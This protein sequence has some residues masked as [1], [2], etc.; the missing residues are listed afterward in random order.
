MAFSCRR[1]ALPTRFRRAPLAPITIG[2]CPA[3]STQMEASTR[4]CCSL[5]GDFFHL[6]RN[7][8]GHLLIEL[9]GEAFADEFGDAKRQIA[10]GERTRRKHRRCHRQ[11]LR[12]AAAQHI[13]LLSLERAHGHDLA[14]CKALGELVR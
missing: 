12:D 5:F 1:T 11:V 10:I 7:A 13:D 2:F 9:E 6:Y 8:V 4:S 3:R 14:K